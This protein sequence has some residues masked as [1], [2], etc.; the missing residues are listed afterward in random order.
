MRDVF[1]RDPCSVMRAHV[2]LCVRRLGP[3]NFARAPPLI[4]SLCYPLPFEDERLSQELL[5]SMRRNV[6]VVRTM[7]ITF[8][9]SHKG[10]NEFPRRV[11]W[12]PSTVKG[13]IV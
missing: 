8:S 10:M 1:I 2:T 13:A 3:H 6:L 7:I 4:E 12:D 9:S 5:G 11:S